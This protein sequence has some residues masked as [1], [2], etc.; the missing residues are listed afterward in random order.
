MR[1]A[2]DFRAELEAYEK[3]SRQVLHRVNK[4]NSTR[5]TFD[6]IV[7]VS[8]NVKAVKSLARI[9]SG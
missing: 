5:Y 6:S 4:V 1:D 7:A 9:V 3:R 2:Y 8:E